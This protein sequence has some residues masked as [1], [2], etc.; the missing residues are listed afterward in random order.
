MCNVGTRQYSRQ[1]P[2]DPNI[3]RK[4][5]YSPRRKV[6][7]LEQTTAVYY[8]S[9]GRF[10]RLFSRIHLSVLRGKWSS[11]TTIVV[12]TSACLVLAGDRPETRPVCTRGGV[13]PTASLITLLNLMKK[14]LKGGRVFFKWVYPAVSPHSWE[15]PW[16]VTN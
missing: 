4:R 13:K 16:C 15:G 7:L 5:S 11:F 2:C 1:Q 12:V 9:S 3:T 8:G 10:P 14:G 6:Q